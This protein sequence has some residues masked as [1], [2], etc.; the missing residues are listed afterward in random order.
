MEEDSKPAAVMKHT[1]QSNAPTKDSALSLERDLAS[2]VVSEKREPA[3]AGPKMVAKGGKNA[4]LAKVKAAQERARSA[5]EAKKKALRDLENTRLEEERILKGLEEELENEGKEDIVDTNSDLFDTLNQAEELSVPS[6]SLPIENT[7]NASPNPIQSPALIPHSTATAAPPSTTV[8]EESIDLLSQS[9]IV[10]VPPPTQEASIAKLPPSFDES[11]DQTQE[12]LAAFQLDADGNQM[13][14]EEQQQMMKEQE[15]ILRQIQQEKEA[16]ERVIN[17]LMQGDSAAAAANVAQSV[18][19][20]D[21][22]ASQS[23]NF[24]TSSVQIAPNKRVALHGQ[25]RTKAAIAAGTAVLVQ[26]IYCQN[27]MQVTPSATLMFCPVC[28]VVSPVQHQSAV[29]TTEEAVRMS[30]DRKMAEKMQNEEYKQ[31]DEEKTE[32]DEG[33]IG[34]LKSSLWGESEQAVLVTNHGGKAAPDGKQSWGQYITSLMP[35][36]NEQPDV[37]NQGS[38]EVVIG[39]AARRQQKPSASAQTQAPKTKPAQING[40]EEDNVESESLLP[41]RVAESKPLFSCMVEQVSNILGGT[42][43]IPEE[44]EV[45]GV[46]A[47]SLLSVPDMRRNND[48]SGAYAALGSQ[49]KF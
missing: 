1:V 39:S 33:I 6:P 13:S 27:W 21:A 38:A 5:Q 2:V 9:S 42:P 29:M 26:C 10:P 32:E 44:G 8:T 20:S 12:Y 15:E 48:G 41:G 25:D 36:A 47:S 4:L 11:V 30:L 40:N 19:T 45:H 34:K 3:P 31:R 28:Q 49:E 14:P 24:K 35:N 22:A 17:E 43:E 7:A 46:D 37:P 16:N 23:K 18:P